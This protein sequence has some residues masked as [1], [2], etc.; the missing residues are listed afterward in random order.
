VSG[1]AVVIGRLPPELLQSPR[2]VL[3]NYEERDGKQT[4]VP[5][6]P[7]RPALKAAV[8]DSSTWG[9]FVDALSAVEDGKADGVGIVLDFRSSISTA[10]A[11][12]RPA[13][14]PRRR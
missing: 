11:T 4:K 13:R 10:A 2:A 7:K 6:D 1:G 5:Y 3:W 8:N 14:S 12:R 9:A